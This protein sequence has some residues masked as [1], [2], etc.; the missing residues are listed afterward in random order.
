[1]P[2]AEE[3]RPALP[4]AT[5]LELG[6]AQHATARCPAWLAVLELLSH[7]L[8]HELCREPRVRSHAG[9]PQTVLPQ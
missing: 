7:H 1:M 6:V 3:A 8:S 2:R 5:E 9:V 4:P